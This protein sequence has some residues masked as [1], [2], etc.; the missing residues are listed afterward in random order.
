MNF[1]E[2][3]A[4]F[5]SAVSLYLFVATFKH[6]CNEKQIK[7]LFFVKVLRIFSITI[8]SS[9]SFTLMFITYFVK[10]SCV[11]NEFCLNSSSNRSYISEHN[12]TYKKKLDNK[13]SLYTYALI[14]KF[15]VLLYRTL[16][17]FMLVSR[18][19]IIFKKAPFNSKSIEFKCNVCIFVGTF[20]AVIQFV[21]HIALVGI[22][23][24]LFFILMSLTFLGNSLCKLYFVYCSLVTFKSFNISNKKVFKRQRKYVKRMKICMFLYLNNDVTLIIIAGALKAFNTVEYDGSSIVVTSLLLNCID[25]TIFLC[26]YTKWK[27]ILTLYIL[28]KLETK[29]EKRNSRKG[30][31]SS[32][33]KSTEPEG[34]KLQTLPMQ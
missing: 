33:T 8:L 32:K 28:K 29:P 15:F 34:F 18:V 6:I 11:R 3:T 2:V 16:M 25:F 5:L 22:E 23:K 14:N 10:F 30:L 1:V 17:N 13:T 24:K 20:L 4:P 19:R 27:S 9:Q 12:S 26:T 31:A 21:G 7:S